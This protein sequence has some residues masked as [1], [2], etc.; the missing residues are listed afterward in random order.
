MCSY[1]QLPFFL[2][3][4]SIQISLF[5][6]DLFLGLFLW[7]RPIVMNKTHLKIADKILMFPSFVATYKTPIIETDEYLACLAE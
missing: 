7:T 3:Y 2:S 4:L 1:V 5:D 6:I